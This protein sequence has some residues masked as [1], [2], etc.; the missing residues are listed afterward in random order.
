VKFGLPPFLAGIA[1]YWFLLVTP[2]ESAV[3]VA[4]LSRGSELVLTKRD[5]GLQSD[6]VV[7]FDS[8]TFVPSKNK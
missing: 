5:D 2:F 7:N 6:C 4:A 8:T 3:V 1:Q